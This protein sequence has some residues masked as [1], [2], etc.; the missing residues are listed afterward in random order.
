M[1]LTSQ[2]TTKTSRFKKLKNSCEKKQ[3]TTI[4]CKIRLM[5][6]EEYSEL[7]V[8]KII[9][10][11]HYQILYDLIQK[12]TNIEYFQTLNITL[13]CLWLLFLCWFKWRKVIKNPHVYCDKAINWS[14][15]R[16]YERFK[17]FF[18]LSTNKTSNCQVLAKVHTYLT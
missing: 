13:R 11:F 12:L 9:K 5:K 4:P 1:M 2:K 16:K 3:Q 18:S 17:Q 15:R 8:K 6:L 7:Q 10:Q 14:V